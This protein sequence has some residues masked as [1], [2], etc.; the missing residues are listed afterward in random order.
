M[1]DKFVVRGVRK[2]F[3]LARTK[4][5][6]AREACTLETK[7]APL[8]LIKM[9]YE[10]EVSTVDEAVKFLDQ[11]R[12]MT[13]FEDDNSLASATLALCEIIEGVKHKYEPQ[14][15]MP[16]LSEE[17]L[18]K[19]EGAPLTI[20]LAAEPTGDGNFIF[21]GEEPHAGVVH[22]S[23]LPSGIAAFIA[24]ALNSKYFSD[25]KRLK[26]ISVKL[27]EQTLL[28]DTVNHA[29]AQYGAAKNQRKHGF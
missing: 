26:N 24:F 7:P 13:D 12:G 20:L 27:G 6:L 19:L 15:Y 11:L 4:I 10:K 22:L 28:F 21:V 23:R 1:A 2:L 29:L 8:P 16:P 5:R 17:E 14:D 18:E 9:I 25:G 3:S